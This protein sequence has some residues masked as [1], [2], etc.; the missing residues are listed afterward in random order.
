VSD[1][2]FWMAGNIDVWRP[3]ALLAIAASFIVGA[4]LIALAVERQR[5]DKD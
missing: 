4:W 5:G 2:L 3:F 1:V